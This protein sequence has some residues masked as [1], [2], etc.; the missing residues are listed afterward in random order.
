MKDIVVG[1]VVIAVVVTTALIYKN[2]KSPKT[3]PKVID[4]TSKQ[5]FMNEFNMEIP[6]DLDSVELKDV[7]G[8]MGR[9]IAT[10]KFEGT[11]THTVLADLPDLE[12]GFYEGWLVRGEVGNSNFGFIST[13]KLKVA[14]GGFL[15]EFSSGTDYSDYGGVVVTEELIF[16]KTPEI[17]ILEGSF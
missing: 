11:F 7:T 14:K 2:L 17:H 3:L 12:T 9:G 6:D 10:R 4:S 8:G 13:G 16:D 15:L 5:D 1:I